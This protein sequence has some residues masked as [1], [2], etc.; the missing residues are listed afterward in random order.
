M[1]IIIEFII[2]IFYLLFKRN[3][4]IIP[5]S[6]ID[7]SSVFEGNNYI[8]RNSIIQNTNIGKYSYIGSNC[9]FSNSIIGRYCSISSNVQIVTGKHPS[10]TFVSTHPAFYSVNNNIGK[11][12]VNHTLFNEFD[13]T[14]NGRNVEIGNDV[15][16]GRNVLIMGGVKIGDGSIIAAGSIVTKDVK[17]YTIVGGVPA[18]IIRLRFDNTDIDKLLRIKWW[19]WSEDKIQDNIS[20]FNNV[21][22]FLDNIE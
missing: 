12:F 22:H 2:G 18:K 21:Q 17:P 1:H 9:I 5:F 19:E 20:L 7:C 16:I 11:T 4:K 14:E 15:W 6:R 3:I 8:G 13:F 10:S